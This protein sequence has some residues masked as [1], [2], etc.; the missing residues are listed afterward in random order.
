VDTV[1][2]SIEGLER[3]IGTPHQIA[4]EIARTGAERGI[5]GRLAIASNPDTAV[6]AARNKSGVTVI[7]LGKELDALASL[8]I[9]AL[10]TDPAILETLESWGIESLGDLAALP[11]TWPLVLGKKEFACSGWHR[12][13]WTARFV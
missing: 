13:G 5:P 12:G 3:L 6:L 8:P 4:S 1:V 11:E 7:P 2:F 10:D 9:E